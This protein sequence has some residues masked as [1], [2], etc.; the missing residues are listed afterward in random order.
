MDGVRVRISRDRTVSFI[1]SKLLK[2]KKRYDME[3]L[4]LTTL[5]LYQNFIEKNFK[6]NKRQKSNFMNEAYKTL[7]LFLKIKLY[8]FA[9][10]NEFYETNFYSNN[11][12]TRAEIRHLS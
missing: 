3:G 9:N 2:G 1:A 5:F 7:E 8:G 4:I 10:L 12:V 11:K 6:P